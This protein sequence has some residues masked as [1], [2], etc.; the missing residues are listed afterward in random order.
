MGTSVV[1]KHCKRYPRDHPHAYGDKS[2]TTGSRSA[3]LGSS[4]R[5]W[6]QDSGR[7]SSQPFVRIIPTRMGTSK[8][9][10]VVCQNIKDHPHAYGDKRRALISLSDSIGSSPRVWGQDQL[11]QKCNYLPLIIPTRMGTRCQ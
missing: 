10:E 5:V 6:G 8:L 1:C 7:T 9:I 2:S 3:K 11:K 4:P